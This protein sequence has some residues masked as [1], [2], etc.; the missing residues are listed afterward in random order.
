MKDLQ[1]DEMAQ[2]FTSM[3]VDFAMRELA[4]ETIL[5][6]GTERAKAWVAKHIDCDGAHVWSGGVVLNV[7]DGR[8]VISLV[9]ADGMVVVEG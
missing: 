6:P 7:H 9:E 8:T 1:A 4:H 3:T 2:A 5:V